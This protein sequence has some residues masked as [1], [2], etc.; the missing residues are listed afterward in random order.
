MHGKRARNACIGRMKVSEYRRKQRTCVHKGEQSVGAEQGHE[1]DGRIEQ[2]GRHILEPPVEAACGCSRTGVCGSVA[3]TAEGRGQIWL[4]APARGRDNRLG[5]LEAARNTC[6][7]VADGK[8]GA[9]Q[10]TVQE[11]ER[12]LEKNVDARCKSE[13]QNWGRHWKSGG[14]GC[15]GAVQVARQLR[16][17]LW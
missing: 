7:H 1:F 15:G 13:G 2:T 16:C 14:A 3:G 5:C 4:G 17:L 12:R 9:R 6:R 8:W 10:R 11:F